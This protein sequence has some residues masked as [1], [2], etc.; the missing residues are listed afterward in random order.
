VSGACYS[1]RKDCCE[2][3]LLWEI[4]GDQESQAACASTRRRYAVQQLGDDAVNECE[5]SHLILARA[6][7][8]DCCRGSAVSDQDHN[9]AERL[10]CCSWTP[11][12]CF[13][14]V[15]TIGGYVAPVR[16]AFLARCELNICGGSFI[17]SNI[18]PAYAR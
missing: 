12:A 1:L 10:K 4:K 14:V 16:Y 15:A 17:R 13:K 6:A 3:E 11:E 8:G 2:D 7:G 18:M 9:L 5:G